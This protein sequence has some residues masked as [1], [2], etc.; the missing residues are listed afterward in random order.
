MMHNYFVNQKRIKNGGFGSFIEILIA[1]VIVSMGVLS[2]FM[3][4]R[5]SNKEMTLSKEFIPAS[6]AAS[7]VLETM[8]GIPYAKFPV[9]KGM[10]GIKN[11]AFFGKLD[12]KI[13]GLDD[14]VAKIGIDELAGVKMI[15]IEISWQARG[16]ESNAEVSKI[17]FTLFKTPF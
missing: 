4:L 15:E 13:P 1:V 10:V 8:K 17:E 11:I 12:D 2:V 3:L 6:N 9:T 16:K 5:S 14:F 7:R